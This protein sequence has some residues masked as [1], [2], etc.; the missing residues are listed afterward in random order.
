LA[1]A[2]LSRRDERRGPSGNRI[3][4]GARQHKVTRQGRNLHL[5][6]KEMQLLLLLARSSGEVVSRTS[7]AEQ[8]WDINFNTGTNMVEAALRRLRS[9]LDD[10][11]EKKLIHNVR[12]V[13]YVLEER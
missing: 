13:G 11:F 3:R 8:V 5:T 4:I 9:K 10:P 12:G 7:I 2:A 1:Q 6:P